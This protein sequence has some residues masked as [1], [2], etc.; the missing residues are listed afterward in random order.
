MIR[1]VRFDRNL[2]D[3][4]D[5]QAAAWRTWLDRH[6][7]DPNVVPVSPRSSDLI[8]DDDS[9]RIYVTELAMKPNGHPEF[10]RETKQFVTRIRVIQLEAPALELPPEPFPVVSLHSDTI[11]DPSC[12]STM[13]RPDPDRVTQE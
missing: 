6:Q 5:D 1:T 3:M 12:H 13:T 2:G 11:T 10:N 7:I 9:R 8:C 4:T